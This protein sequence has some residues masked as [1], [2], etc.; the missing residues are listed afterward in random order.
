MKKI[1]F[2]LLMA[3]VASSGNAV[4]VQKV[5]LKNGSELNGYIQQQDGSGKL[6][7]HTDCA[8]IYVRS[9][10]AVVYA[11]K[12]KIGSLNKVW[13]EWAEKNDAFEGIGE[14]R[15]LELND[16]S[17]RNDFTTAD[18]VAVD[19]KDMG[20]YD[21]LKDSQRQ[22]SGVK[23]LQRG[24][25]VKYLELTPNTYIISWND[26]E[27]I[28]GIRRPKTMLSG[29]NRIYEL[30]NGK[31]YEGQYA[32]E[33]DNT[34]SLYLDN[35][36]VETF[37]TDDVIKYTFRPINP[38][39]DIFEQSELVEIVKTRNGGQ[40]RGIII[41]QNYSSKKDSENYLLVQTESGAIRSIKISDFAELRKEENPRY[42][43]KSDIVL[44]EGDVVI[45]RMETLAV[46]VTEKGDLLQLDSLTQKVVLN[47]GNNLSTKVTV[48]YRTKNAANVDAFQLIKVTEA[49]VKKETI[50]TFSYKDLV[51]AVYR[52]TSIETSINKTTKAE[53]SVPG[54][55]IFALYNAKKKTAI[56]FI[57]K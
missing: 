51:N 5:T 4:I 54:T 31:T 52:P 42:D 55:G 27:S 2:S 14:N 50:Y 34:M 17:F 23:V 24:V 20:F 6:T 46:K 8:T 39:Q 3:T 57:I 30:R 40:T 19:P 12:V 48:E 9:N 16:V 41:E 7:F 22:I 11:S 10:N 32:G 43:P 36:M 18:S 15:T 28:E 53:Y 25:M 49:K 35:G 56:P 1:I 37:N 38:N 33:T 29:I 13:K 44:H 45:N 47:K 26:I 21:Y